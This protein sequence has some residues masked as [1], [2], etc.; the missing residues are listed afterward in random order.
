MRAVVAAIRFEWAAVAGGVEGVTGRR[1]SRLAAFASAPLR[2]KRKQT[3]ANESNAGAGA[4]R[5]ARA[6]AHGRGSR[7]PPIGGVWVEGQGGREARR[8]GKGEG[9]APR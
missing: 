2:L 8:E 4:V 3:K 7:R 6:R 9:E 5:A 1:P